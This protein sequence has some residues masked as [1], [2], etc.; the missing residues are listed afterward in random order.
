VVAP[1]DELGRFAPPWRR[2]ARTISEDAGH[3]HDT[4]S[5]RFAR[6]PQAN[7]RWRVMTK[8]TEA[9]ETLLDQAARARRLALA[10]EGDPAAARLEQLAEELEAKIVR[11]SFTTMQVATDR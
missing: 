11:N 10:I 8:D 7:E 2:I 3:R 4:L 9:L 6:T 5:P 1:E